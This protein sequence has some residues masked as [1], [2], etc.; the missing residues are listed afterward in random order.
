MQKIYAS[1]GESKTRNYNKKI[2]FA[3][4][5][6]FGTSCCGDVLL[7]KKFFY[8]MG[9]QTRRG[10]DDSRQVRLLKKPKFSNVLTYMER[11]M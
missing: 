10:W 9:G 8:P 1:K 3:L 4:D 6:F 7:L 5:F 2:E 11:K